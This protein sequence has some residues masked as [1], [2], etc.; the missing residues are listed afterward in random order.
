MPDRSGYEVLDDLKSD[1]RTK[2]IPVIIHTSMALTQNDY[3]RLGNRQVAILPKSP[4]GRLPALTAI[5]GLLQE[6]DLFSAEPEF[7]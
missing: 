2:H 7:S 6:P 3:D 4:E 1:D 5:R